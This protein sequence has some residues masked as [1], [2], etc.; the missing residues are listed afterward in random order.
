MQ[1]KVFLQIYIGDHLSIYLSIY[2]L[3]ETVGKEGLLIKREKSNELK[4]MSD[5][6]RY[7]EDPINR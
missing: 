1:K 2:L 5:K 6:I 7:T 3:K 4:N